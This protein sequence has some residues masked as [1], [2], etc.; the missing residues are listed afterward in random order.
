MRFLKLSFALLL[1]VAPAAGSKKLSEFPLRVAILETHWTSTAWGTNG[2]G[3]GNVID[4]ELI[5]GFDYTFLCPEPFNATQG[6]AVYLARWKKQDIRLSLLAAEIGNSGKQ[7][8][9]ELK[10]TLSAGVYARVNGNLIVYTH[11]QYSEIIAARKSLSIAENPPDTDPAHFP[12]RMSVL[13]SKWEHGQVGGMVG[14]GRGNLRNGESVEAFD[15]SSLCPSELSN[16]A[17]GDTYRARWEQEGTRLLVLAHR[18]GTS[19]YHQCELKIDLRPTQVFMRDSKTGVVNPIT[20][21]QFKIWRERRSSAQASVP[22][23]DLTA[24]A[25]G[26][27]AK[28]TNADIIAM[29]KEGLSPDIVLAKIEASESAFDTSPDGLGALKAAGTPNE[30][31]IAMI[32][33][34]G[35]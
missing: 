21:E 10:T 35:N 9:C 23:I 24:N 18:I 30:I 22:K 27:E 16:T 25:A 11:Q 28:L 8:E 6:S 19:E 3:R 14:I 15:F 32:K 26:P 4:G 13:E 12:L 29:V 2:Y 5:Q 31:V 20:Q 7:R 1:L 17:D 33:K 34:S